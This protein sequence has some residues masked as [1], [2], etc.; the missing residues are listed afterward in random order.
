[1][2]SIA[3]GI[4]NGVVG[5]DACQRVDMAIGV[6]ANQGAV[7]E[8]HH[9]LGTQICFEAFLYLGLREGLVSVGGHQATG[10]GKNGAFAIALDRAAL[11][12][13]VEMVFVVALDQSLLV[14]V[15][16]DGVVELRLELLAP[17][18]ELEIKKGE[19]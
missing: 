8:P 13:E 11:E 5:T 15:L 6:I 7:V 14:E 12:D 1:M 4:D 18:V 9:A 2:V 19:G 16:V 10:G 3:T 17:A